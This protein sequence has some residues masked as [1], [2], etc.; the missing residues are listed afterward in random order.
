MNKKVLV[1]DDDATFVELV[2]MVLT[3]EGF[4][5]LT[6]SN[7]REA[8]R[9]LFES[10]PDLVLLDVIMPQ[11]DG[12]QT[13]KYIREASD[14]PIIILSGQSRSEDD[15]V[16]G[17]D[18]GAD[19]YILKPISN[20]ELAARVKAI[21]R[22][23][24]SPPSKETEQSGIYIDDHL[25]VNIKERKVLV[26]GERVRLTPIEF[27]LFAQLMHNAGKVLTHRQLLEKVWGWEYTDDIDY[28]RIYISHLRQKIEENPSQ[29]RY[30]ITD[31]GVGYYFRKNDTP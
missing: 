7:G 17:L 1:V 9:I 27:R 13:C 19:E 21:L 5:I 2:D 29:P 14:V 15:I 28:V 3:R 16:R 20:R 10:K 30:I 11:M 8:L 23:A 25:V 12:W 24:E 6:A 18:H 31:P 26:E 4:E 22:R